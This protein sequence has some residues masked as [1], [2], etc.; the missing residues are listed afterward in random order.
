[1]LLKSLSPFSQNHGSTGKWLNI[2][3]VTTNWEI[4]PLFRW[5]M[6]IKGKHWPKDHF[7]HSL[8]WE[9]NLQKRWVRLAPFLADM[10]SE[11]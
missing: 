2:W 10:V 4:H 5:T 7:F 9:K 6:I 3:K 1:M 11:G 8:D